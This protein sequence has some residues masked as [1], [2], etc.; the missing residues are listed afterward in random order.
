MKEED[1]SVKQRRQGA[2]I[3]HLG[4]LHTCGAE[5]PGKCPD[6]SSSEGFWSLEFLFHCRG[7]KGRG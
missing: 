4:S 2:I 1:R 3:P 7:D 5:R 6:A